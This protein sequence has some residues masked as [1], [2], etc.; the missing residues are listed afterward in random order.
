MVSSQ[1]KAPEPRMPKIPEIKSAEDLLPLARLIVKRKHHD[2]MLDGMGLKPGMKVLMVVD[3]TNDRLVQ[4]AFRIA[5]EEAGGILEIIT[6]YGYPKLKDPLE[7]V[8]T[9]FSRRWW[10]S[11]IWP[12]IKEA[13]I[14]L[15][16]A[17]MK[18]AHT[19]NLPVDTRK[20]PRFVDMEWT[21]DLLAS[22]YETFPA[23]V[24][25]AIDK[26]TWEMM[27]NARKLEVKDLEGTHI[28]ATLTEEDWNKGIERNLKSEG[29]PYKPNHLQIPL[30][31]RTT[32]G[33]F[34]TSS[35]TFGGPIPRTS[36]TIQEG[37]I[38]EVKGA[39][40]FGDVLRQSLE[41][42]DV[43]Q[44]PGSLGLCTHPKAI[45]SPQYD[46]LTGSQR[47]HAWAFGHRRSGITHSPIIQGLVK[48]D[49]KI[50]RHIGQHFI[51]IILDGKTIVNRGHMLALDASQVRKIAEKYGD[52][53]KLLKEDWI[54]AVSGVN[55]P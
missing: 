12:A 22:D 54:P 55:A 20:K 51:T 23:E 48:E 52:P 41:K 10:P 6:L 2:E 9:L 4:D 38:K 24:R 18:T 27:V 1:A 45:S 17:M 13:D 8:D 42:G 46:N 44:A 35:L 43:I 5:V 15:Q 30:T 39:G 34:V 28:T 53:D 31:N 3:T 40:K 16:G 47:V 21:A 29:L 11:W 25:D 19:P 36:L 7:L 32:E 49:Y 33:V 14:V 50:T 37:L 26:V